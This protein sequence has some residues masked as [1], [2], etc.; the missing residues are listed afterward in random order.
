MSAVLEYLSRPLAGVSLL[1]YLRDEYYIGLDW[2]FMNACYVTILMVGSAL[3]HFRGKPFQPTT[4]P[5]IHN[6]FLCLLSLYMCLGG[7]YYTVTFI[8]NH[9][10]HGF[11]CDTEFHY[12]HDSPFMSQV[13]ILFYLSKYYE[14]IDSF[15][16]VLRSSGFGSKSRLTVLHV[17]HHI[18]TSLNCSMAWNS[19]LGNA[20]IITSIFNAGIHVAMY[21]YYA[22]SGMYD[23]RPWWKKYLTQMQINQFIVMELIC[24]GWFY[25]RYVADDQ[26][27]GSLVV[28]WNGVFTVLSFLLLFK[29]F[30]KKTYGPKKQSLAT[31]ATHHTE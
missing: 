21:Y 9:G 3:M 2:W 28:F 29:S 18:T 30:Q 31:K 10:M 15:I 12:S 27:P 23:Y 6:I 4:F 26:C 11:Y 7:I 5:I 25:F 1:E 19:H 17:W 13:A 16:L 24:T 14:F 22:L 20:L 8:L